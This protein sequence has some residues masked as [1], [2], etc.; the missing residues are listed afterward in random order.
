MKKRFLISFV[1]ILVSAFTFAQDPNI[2][3]Y[4]TDANE[5]YQNEQYSDA[6]ELYRKVINE[7]FESVPL[8]YNLGN[9]YYRES[10]LGM[11]ILYY[12]KA[13]KIDPNDE[14]VI[15]NLNIVKAHT[16]D[17]FKEI[18]ELFLVSWWNSIVSALTLQTWAVVVVLSFLSLLSF[19]GV[20]LLTKSSSLQKSMFYISAMNLV[21]FVIFAILMFS[22]FNLESSS[23]Y[24]ILTDSIISAK[25]SPD[26]KSN[27]AF[28]IHEG[29]KFS[30]E[31]ELKGWIKI[32]LSDGKVGWLPKTSYEEI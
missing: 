5:L 13:L 31:D 12:E 6:I 1:F 30:V 24:G 28:V 22:K 19:I 25:L 9:S 21:V 27:D 29:V 17:K 18:P 3:K 2:E 14:D 20:Y 8:Y 15:H 4:I 23:N 11:A 26:I 10:K 7:G 16:I 32:K